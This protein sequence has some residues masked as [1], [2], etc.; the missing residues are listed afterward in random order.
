MPNSWF[1]QPVFIP[2]GDP[3]QMNEPTRPIL[4]GK[5]TVEDYAI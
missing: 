3:E 4:G 2:G 5:P 1:S